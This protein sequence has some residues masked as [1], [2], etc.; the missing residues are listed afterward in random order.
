MGIAVNINAFHP[1]YVQMYMPEFMSV[2]RKE[3]DQMANGKKY[4]AISR[5]KKPSLKP[6]EFYTYSL[7][8]VPKVK[9]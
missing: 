2:I 6:T 5:A 9:K 1:Q 7:A 4:G 8:G 3:A